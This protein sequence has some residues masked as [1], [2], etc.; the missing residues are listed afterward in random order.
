MGV[1]KMMSLDRFNQPDGHLSISFRTETWLPARILLLEQF[2][3]AILYLPSHRGSLDK[4]QT[5]V[6]GTDSKICGKQLAQQR[7]PMRR[8]PFCPNGWE[9]LDRELLWQPQTTSLNH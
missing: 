8:G 4:S 1:I 6:E 7:P 9:Y 3:L 5:A 2:K